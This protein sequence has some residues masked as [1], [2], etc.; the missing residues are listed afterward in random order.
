[1]INTQSSLIISTLIKHGQENE[2]V[3]Q[4]A[5]HSVKIPYYCLKTGLMIKQFDPPLPSLS[6]F[7]RH[8]L[9]P[10]K[11]HQQK[12]VN[13]ADIIPVQVS[14]QQVAN[15]V[16]KTIQHEQIHLRMCSSDESPLTIQEERYA[17]YSGVGIK[18][19][20]TQIFYFVRLIKTYKYIRMFFVLVICIFFSV[21]TQYR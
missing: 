21:H 14:F 19:L 17:Y 16:S 12:R 4:F 10:N 18:R 3:I 5:W 7:L 13:A 1:M 9:M 6:L 2:W 15:N 11:F 8:Q 20:T